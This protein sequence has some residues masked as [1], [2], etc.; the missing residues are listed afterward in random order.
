MRDDVRGHAV[1]GAAARQ[2]VVELQPERASGPRVHER[3][4]RRFEWQPQEPGRLLDE[5]R[6]SRT[7][8]RLLSAEYPRHHGLSG[9]IGAN[10]SLAAVP[11]RGSPSPLTILE[12]ARGCRA[13]SSDPSPVP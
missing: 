11:L 10:V 5:S 9:A 3:D 6:P 12:Y 7:H 13:T 2:E 1:L 4:R 8:P